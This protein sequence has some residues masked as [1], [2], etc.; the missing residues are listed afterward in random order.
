VATSPTILGPPVL[1]GTELAEWFASTGKHANITVSMAELAQDYA[2]AGQLTAVRDDLAFAQSIIETGFF[3]FPAGGQLT[4]Q[5]NN[6]AGIGACDSCAHGWS[7]ADARTG[8][9]AQLEL[10]DAYASPTPVPTPLIG[11]VGVGGCCPTWMALAGKWASSLVY[12]ISI[13]TIYHH[14][15]AWVIPQRLV[16]A[17]LLARTAPAPAKGPTRATLPAKSSPAKSSPANEPAAK[18]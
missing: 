7:F 4:P 6:F 10:L 1:S 15:L 3:A 17:G 9:T 12:G 14:M 8:V 18:R 13:M 16:A 11:P 5:D 2:S